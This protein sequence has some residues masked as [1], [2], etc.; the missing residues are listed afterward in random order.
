M[1]QSRLQYKSMKGEK[2][3]WAQILPLLWRK[4]EESCGTLI[5]S[6]SF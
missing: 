2:R 4:D 1:N 3:L 5:D 6:I